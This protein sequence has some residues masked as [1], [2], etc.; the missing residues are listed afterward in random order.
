MQ[1]PSATDRD[2]RPHAGTR[3]LE[4]IRVLELGQ[5]IAGPFAGSLLAYF[6]A[7]VIKVETPGTGDP[8]RNWRVLKNGTSLWWR[9]MG[10]NKKCITL[11]LRDERGRALARQLAEQ[12]DVLIENFK[13]DTLEKWN[14]GP[15]VLEA[16]N[17]GLI[18]AR[19][20]GYGQDG[21]YAARPGFASACEGFGGLRYIN[22]HP[23]QVPVRPNLSL[24]D[25][26]AAVHAVI[27]V[28]L[29]LVQRQ[30]TN[31]QSPDAQPGTGRGQTVDVA[32]FESVYN[33]LESVVPEY[34]GAGIVRE[35]SGSTLT[36]IV[37]TNT[38]TCGDGKH[39]V[40]GGNNDSIFKRLMRA[41]DRADL[42]AD[43]RLADNAGR[44]AH[45]AEVDGAIAHWTGQRAQAQAL[46]AME[47]ASV[48]CGPIN[49][50]A[51]MMA[52]PHFRARGLFEQ[53]EVDGE[54]LDI[55]ALR[56]KLSRTPGKTLWPGPEVGAHNAEVFGELGLGAE[57]IEQLRAHGVL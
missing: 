11:N 5:L 15:E 41:I 45:Q 42:A 9:S 33:M 56:P 39:V 55:P 6:G 22:G 31:G 18:V 37:P 24:G 17:P 29:A 36:G 19:I 35:P 13:P 28:L 32:I 57:E 27:G 23:E 21:P 44:V 12:V 49:S 26:L 43:P 14:M 4:G 47:A 8:L 53:V 51:D 46:A 50:V 34:S 25:T 52:D 48:P 10:R 20:S 3:P 30:R 1:Q 7:E 40:I 16:A 38:Y 2:T 54:P